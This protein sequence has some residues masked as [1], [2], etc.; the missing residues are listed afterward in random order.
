M[1]P[2][3]IKFGLIAGLIVGVVL[4]GTTVA[5]KGHPPPSWGMALGFA[6][7]LIA[8][9]AVFVG[10]KQHRDLVLGGVIRFWP[11]FGMGLLISLVAS[12]CYVIAWEAALAVTKIDF[13]GDYAK[14]LIAQQQAKGVSGEALAKFVAEMEAFKAQYA[15]PLYRWGITFTEIFPVGVLV[16]LITAALIRNSRFM[17]LKRR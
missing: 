12:V 10:V 2:R 8:L 5:L 1:F 16:S 6:S 13:A 17:P 9:S 3:V 7:M 15:K 11:A 4:F 14:I